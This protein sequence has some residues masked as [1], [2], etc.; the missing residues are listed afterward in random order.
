MSFAPEHPVVWTEIPV[1]DLAAGRSFYET[2]FQW[3]TRLME[4]P[5]NDFAFFTAEEKGTSGHLYPGAAAA[6]GTGPTIH[7][8]VPGKLEEAIDRVWDAGG[9]VLEQPPVEL[10]QG[11]FVYALDPDGNSIGL[12]EP[13]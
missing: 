1:T 4:H 9:R 7:L 11:R 2:V 8:A 6:S 5:E 10:P 3:K 13:A 12:F